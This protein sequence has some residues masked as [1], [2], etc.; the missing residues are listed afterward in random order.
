MAGMGNTGNRIMPKRYSTASIGFAVIA[1]VFASIDATAGRGED[2][3]EYGTDPARTWYP[4]S[5]I[6]STDIPNIVLKES[7]ARDEPLQVYP[8][9]ERTWL[10]FGNVAV[11]DAYNRGWTGNA[12]FVVTN[13]GVVVIDAL[14][15]PK[16]GERLIATIKTVTDKPIRYLIVTHNHPDHAYGAVAF[17]RL[18]GVTIISHKGAEQYFNS[19]RWETSVDFRRSIIAPDMQGFEFVLPDSAIGGDIFSRHDIVVGGVTFEIYNVGPHHSFGDLV[20]HQ[21]EDN[22]VWVS[23]LAFNGRTTFIGDGNSKQALASIDWLATTFPGA[24][25]MVPGH[26]SAQTA[27]FPMVEKTRSYIERLRNIMAQAIEDDVGLQD[28]VEQAEFEDWKDTR[29]YGANQPANA[30]FIYRELEEELF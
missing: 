1:M 2:V 4:D 16:L 11:A 8:L 17:K 28:A 6:D 10:L 22:I 19:G 29:L 24:R 7:D 21:V 18:G 23:D 13:D 9:N 3:H 27:P 25:L 15:T 20:V 5:A 26:G 30:S 14:G 12:G